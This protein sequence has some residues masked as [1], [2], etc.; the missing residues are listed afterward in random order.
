[1]ITTYKCN[2]ACRECCFECNPRLTA[3]LS[4][5]E[6]TGFIDKA[7]EAFPGLRLVVFSGGECF[8]LGDDLLESIRYATENNL[9]TRCVTNG[10]WGRTSTAANRMAA[11]LLECGLKE[12]NVSTGADHAEWVPVT[13]A[14]NAAKSAATQGLFCVITV[15]QDKT[16]GEIIRQVKNDQALAELERAGLV[17]IQVNSWMPFHTDSVE[18][19]AFQN[20]ESML[21]QGCDQV[22]ENCVLTPHH[23][24]S[25]CCGLTFEHIPE[26]KFNWSPGES[27][28]D[29]YLSQAQDFL[30]IWIKVEGPFQIIKEVA[31][32]EY[33]DELDKIVHP[34]QACVLLH[35]SQLIRDRIIDQYRSHMARVLRK[36]FSQASIAVDM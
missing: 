31:L 7:I 23:E 27:L 36:F 13:C 9:L 14:L 15:E 35:Q 32:E 26:M 5:K 24:I 2:A 19:V 21:C 20:R 12:L 33:R 16:G 22:I 17:K 25:G 30:K 18:R 28:R 29:R 11:R 4:R 3:R 6:I 8:L 10:F 1:M 34:C